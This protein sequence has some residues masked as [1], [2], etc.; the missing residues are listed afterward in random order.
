[1]GATSSFDF[2]AK[3][4]DKAAHSVIVVVDVRVGTTS[5]HIT[6]QTEKEYY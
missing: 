2:A 3:P 5:F 1:M 4:K 6:W